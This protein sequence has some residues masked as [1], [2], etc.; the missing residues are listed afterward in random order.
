MLRTASR[1]VMN[2]ASR[3]FSPRLREAF[4]V[5]HTA[6]LT[7][8]EAPMGYGKTMA[9]REFLGKTRARVVWTAILDSSAES[10]W[11]TFCRELARVVPEA[12]DTAQALLR[13]GFPHDS[14]RADAARDLLARVDFAKATVLAFDDTHFLPERQGGRAF[15][16]FCELLA[17]SGIPRL[18]LVCIARDIWAGEGRDLLALKGV[19]SVI[20]REHFVLGPAEISE[21]YARCGIALS[22]GDARELYAATGGWISALYLYLL[23]YGKSGVSGLCHKAD[24]RPEGFLS[25]AMRSL[26]EKEVYEPLSPELKEL[27]FA[28]APL[29]QATAGQADFLYNGDTHKL[30]AELARKNSFVSFD[31]KSGIYTQHSIFKQYVME[32]FTRL[33]EERQQAVRRKC[34]DWFIRAGEVA[35]AM[36]AYRAAGDFERALVALE[37]DMARHF[38]TEKAAFFTEMFK[39]CPEEILERHLGA[40]FK[41]A[42]A[43]FSAAD[44]PAFGA[45]VGWLAKRC[46]AL[47][48]GE[49]ADSW[50]GELEF[51]LSLAAFNNIA[52]MSVHH[53][54]ANEL[55]GRPTSLFGVDSPWTLGSPSVLFMFHRERGKLAEEI[56]LMHEC[57]PHYYTLARFHGAGGEWLMEAEAHYNAGRFTE[58]EILCHRAEAMAA[59]HRQLANVLC[60]LFLRMRLALVVGDVSGRSGFDKA[61]GLVAA[62]RGLIRNSRDYF[63]LHTVDLCEGWLYAALD[64]KEDIPAWLCSELAESSRLYAFARGWYY[65][66]HGRA[67][68]FS[69]EYARI[70]GLFGHLLES[71]TFRNNLLF[72]LYGRIYQAVAQHAL[73]QGE[74]AYVTLSSALDDALPDELYMPFAENY[75]FLTPLLK[76]VERQTD[77]ALA[78]ALAHIR[79]LAVRLDAGKAAL[80]EFSDGPP[81]FGLSPR[82]YE[83]ARLAA[84]GLSNQEIAET[85]FVSLNTVKTHLK[86]AYGKTGAT[87]RP[88]LKRML[89]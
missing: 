59:E 21:Y 53:R 76:P 30:L 44:F 81:P 43:A 15:A 52:G 48:P 85:L 23:Q 33:P 56:R 82:E 5:L 57:L 75:D 41:Y 66:V 1:R 39:A 77:T 65:F 80:R 73:G 45:Q 58:A 3:Y 38:V 29:E 14:V 9:A 84:Q 13:L 46:A 20:N 11:N 67:L 18:R 35:A 4:A 50:R 8:V 34:G 37:S 55:L 26:V 7:V 25:P 32:R 78:Q 10:C 31:P 22:P 86:A 54:R 17:Q 28:L 24:S 83:T 89:Q 2:A 6:P 12:T 27:L 61:R 69:G 63:L 68:L 36:E 62:M 72:S 70:S 79:T 19:L 40:A 42:I 71:G 88:A 16:H 64:C 60:A 47:P 87:S 49:E 74:Q 51:L